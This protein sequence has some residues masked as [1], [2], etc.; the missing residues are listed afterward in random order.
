M[1]NIRLSH[2]LLMLFVF[3]LS[4]L[5]DQIV[6]ILDPAV[7]FIFDLSTKEIKPTQYIKDSDPNLLEQTQNT[8]G[9]YTTHEDTFLLQQIFKTAGLPYYITHRLSDLKNVKIIFIDSQIDNPLELNESDKQFLYNFVK[10]GGVLIGND[11]L[12]TKYGAL[13][14]LFGYKGF[15]PSKSHYQFNLL[16]S[17]PYLN[18][19]DTYEEKHYTLSTINT[20]PFTNTI[21]PG[22]ATTI[23]KYDDDSAAITTN[24][25]GKGIA[26]NM[27]I[28][29]YNLRYRNLLDK[30]FYANKEPINHFEP[31][32]DFIVLFLKDIYEQTLKQSITLHTSR[33][34]NQATVIITHNIDNKAQLQS[35]D[36]TIKV[37]SSLDVKSTCFINVKYLSDKK[38]NAFFSQENFKYILNLQAQNVEIGVHAKPTKKNLFLLEK[39]TCQEHYP[40]YQKF[41][42]SDLQNNQP[43]IC[44]EAKVPKELLQAIGIENIESFRGADLIYN[45][46]IPEVLPQLG[47][48]YT[49]NFSAEDVLSYFPYKYPLDY[50]NMTG[51]SNIVEIPVSYK[52]NSV[53]PLY[54]QTHSVLK[55]FKKIYNNGGIFQMLISSDIYAID[56]H[57]LDNMFIKKFYTSLPKDVWK[58]SIKEYG[59]FWNYRNKI[60]YR[61]KI[62]NNNLI[63]SIYSPTNIK[64]ITFKTNN[65]KF[66]DQYNIKVKG[67]KFSI[68]VKQG[69][70]RW[71]FPLEQ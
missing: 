65:I 36:K 54:L 69:Y 5:K 63:M 45:K 49:S 32:S 8:I 11:I 28:S 47:Y 41:G 12:S 20:A 19:F 62:E 40:M 3:V 44:G 22:T 68:D 9:I 23:A 67:D 37:E 52:N 42:I 38:S 17:S 4:T 60:V 16:S 33:Y 31:L 27:G 26:I 53:W 46:Y 21:I 48:R 43:T 70:Y 59:K 1:K 18:Y 55:L 30:D 64:G 10:K 56:G 13:K 61:Y 6:Y 50:N 51:A 7:P 35:I 24:Q 57:M 71:V 34:N 2:I 58:A 29:L 15:T 25:Y 14:E 39:G 66:K